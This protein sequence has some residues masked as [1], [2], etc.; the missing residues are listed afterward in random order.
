VDSAE[1][2]EESEDE[3][4]EQQDRATW[5][6]EDRAAWGGQCLCGG[7]GYH[8]SPDEGSPLDV[9]CMCPV[10]TARWAREVTQ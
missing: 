4:N 2:R 3:V 7:R 1:G 9:Y 10:G 6:N 8:A 5:W